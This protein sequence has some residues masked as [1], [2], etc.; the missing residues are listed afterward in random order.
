MF[1]SGRSFLTGLSQTSHVCAGNLM[2]CK[3]NGGKQR[4]YKRS[5]RTENETLRY[6]IWTC[7]NPV[8]VIFTATITTI[9][10]TFNVTTTSDLVRLQGGLV[11]P[12]TLLPL[13]ER[14]A[15]IT[16]QCWRKCPE[17]KLQKMPPKSNHGDL[18][19][20][21]LLVYVISF[22]FGHSPSDPMMYGW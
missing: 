11:M 8:V 19:H 13:L 20:L 7:W 5:S 6:P 10:A 22:R 17:S 14:V 3:S 1:S 4:S 21:T 9:A 12:R 2:K 15:I 16:V 18:R